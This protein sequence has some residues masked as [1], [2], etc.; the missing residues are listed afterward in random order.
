MKHKNRGFSL[1]E[2]MLVLVVLVGGAAA[3]YK[4]FKPS[5]TQ[6]AVRLEQE[7]VGR[8]V[9]AIMGAYSTASNFSTL[10]TATAAGV[11]NVPMGVNG[12]NSVMRT[13]VTIVPA[14]SLSANDSFDMVYAS[15]S[16]EK[17]IA[18]IPALRSRSNGVFVG[19][20]NNL[21]DARGAITNESLIATQ[22]SAAPTTRVTFRFR[23][24]KNTFASTTTDS[25]LCA[26]ETETQTLACPSGSGSITQRRTATCTGGTP[27][28]PAAQWSSWV[29]A[30]N[31][32]AADATPV[33]PQVP[34]APNNTCA[35]ATEYQNLNCPSGQ[36]GSIVQ[37]RTQSCTTNTWGAWTDLQNSCRPI[38]NIGSCTPGTKTTTFACPSGQGGQITAERPVQCDANGREVPFDESVQSNW[39][40]VNS[41]CTAS[42]VANGNC[43]TVTR[44]RVETNT[45]QCAT[46]SYGPGVTT[47]RQQSSSC[48]THDGAPVWNDS[49]WSQVGSATGQCNTCTPNQT[50]QAVRWVARAGSCPS[51]QTGVLT[52]NDEQVQDVV[53][54]RLCNSQAGVLNDDATTTVSAWRNTGNT[55]V[56]S[57]T[58]ANI[59]TNVCAVALDSEY[60]SGTS[61]TRD[62]YY[63]ILY[64]IQGV[65]GGCSSNYRDNTDPGYCDTQA[66]GR[67]AWMNAARD[68]ERYTVSGSSSGWGGGA[69]EFWGWTIEV[70]ERRSGAACGTSNG[71]YTVES[72]SCSSETQ[73]NVGTLDQQAASL[74]QGAITGSQHTVHHFPSPQ[75]G[76]YANVTCR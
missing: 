51:G 24:D 49:G 8:M 13:D 26:P 12:L 27:I 20:N 37:Y 69:G 28:C 10:S 45:T 43:C 38:V 76:C 67:D 71:S 64:T 9:D 25:C 5:Q 65:P 75:V 7:N 50:T 18:L 63:N 42:C 34:V 40:I 73:Q 11:L 17:C 62:A 35:A 29:T 33:A 61:D 1:L 46:G 44:G 4:I 53:T 54:T 15:L 52:Y 21:Q 30:N 16:S 14:T 66:L 19:N 31:T 55:V 70:F 39:K 48:P 56:A 47:R 57:N 72:E 3:A 22:C 74:C 23:A 32:C 6:A 60:Q 68:G 59:P 41:T 36:T 2:L 58:C